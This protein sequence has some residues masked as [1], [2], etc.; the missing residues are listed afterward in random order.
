MLGIFGTRGFRV[1]GTGPEEYKLIANASIRLFGLLA[2][3]A[4]LFHIDLA[5][6]YILIAFPLGTVVLIFSRWMWRQWLGMQRMTRP[7]LVPRRA[8]RLR[9]VDLTHCTGTRAPVGCRLLRDRCLCPWQVQRSTTSRTHRIPVLGTIDDLNT[10]L[11][12]TG[13]D[14]VVVTS[15]GELSA[16]RMR[17]L[18]WS[19]E[20]GKQ[21]LVVAPSLTG[22]SGPRIHTRPVAGLPLI[23]VETPTY[24]GRK[25]FTKR[26]FDIVSSTLLLIV[27]SPVFA[28]IAVA[29]RLGGPGPILF[30]Q[31][32]VGING[33][34]FTVLKFRSMVPGAEAQLDDLRENESCRRQRGDVQDEE[35]PTGHP[36]RP[37]PAQV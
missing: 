31:E 19:L 23:H 34:R 16:R 3:A 37:V 25:L 7:L 30:G 15:S 27:L 21:H 18:S 6:G 26:V 22:V 28:A 13:A 17:E 32:R 1:L 36:N 2:I 11:E 10:A 35:R 12:T 8:G 24:D 33:D 20:P 29:I 5:R 9:R 14:T 4:F